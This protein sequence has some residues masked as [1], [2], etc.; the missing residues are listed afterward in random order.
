MTYTDIIEWLLEGDVSIQY[1]TNR[2]LLKSDLSPLRKRI[3]NEGWGFQFLAKRDESRQQWGS[4]FYNPKWIS[5]HYTLLDLRNLCVFPVNLKIRE[6]I[7]LIIKNEKSLDGGIKPFG[8]LQISDVCVNGMFLNYASYFEIDQKSLNSVVDF[9]INQKMKDGG[10]NCNSNSIG[11]RHSS[12][13]TTLSV[14]E[15]I[16]EYIKNGYSYRLAELQNAQQSCREFMLDHELFKSDKTGRAINQK[17]LRFTYP[18]RWFYDI[19]RALDYFRYTENEF[20]PRMEA[21]INVLVQKRG[22]DKRWKLQ[23]KHPGKT[24]FEM[25]K[26]GEPS[27]W[28]TLRALRILKHFGLYNVL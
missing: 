8:K 9:L 2:D 26:T 10:F 23:S 15:G 14:A 27:R 22:K 25:E 6:T 17:M 21:A 12:L 7:E 13:H 11:A 3:E 20:D 28:N 24:H 4:G 18:S 16:F 19:F 5:T 1:Q